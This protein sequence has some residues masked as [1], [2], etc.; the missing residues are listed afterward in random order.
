MYRFIVI[1]IFCSI[2]GTIAAQDYA[3]NIRTLASDEQLIIFY[4]LSE[5]ADIEVH[6]S[7]DDGATFQG[8]LLNVIGAV[9]RDIPAEYDKVIVWNAVSELGDVDYPNAV[10]K[11]VTT[12]APPPEPPRVV[13]QQPSFQDV[14]EP[15]V[16]YKPF[17]VDLCVGMPLPIGGLVLIEPKYAVVPKL[18]IGLKFETDIIIREQS[19][20][21]AIMSYFLTADFHFS[22]TSKIRPFVGAGGGLYSIGAVQSTSLG[23]ANKADQ[24]NN[25]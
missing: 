11:I 16:G 22:A 2:F 3:S 19:D 9:G 15:K 25:F 23:T 24:V 21:Q 17:R 12:V 18:S 1:V 6:V 5:K 4:D 14:Q 10:I 8:P 7:F 20:I 13:E